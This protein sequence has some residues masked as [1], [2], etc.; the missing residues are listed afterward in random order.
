MNLFI[1]CPI[2][3]KEDL[4]GSGI[5]VAEGELFQCPNCGQLLSSCSKKIYINSNQSWDTEEGTWPSKNDYG[6]LKKRRTTDINI[7]AKL[8]S[9]KYSEIRLL[10][11]GC[12]DGNL[13]RNIATLFPEWELWGFDLASET[14]SR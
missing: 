5:L 13:L 9:K 11:V 6:R 4:I 8:L 12:G 14:V 2:G 7:L 10:D 3:C 1:D